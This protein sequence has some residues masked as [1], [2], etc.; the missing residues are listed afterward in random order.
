VHLIWFQKNLIK[1]ITSQFSSLYF[2]N[3]INEFPGR[4]F[5]AEEI[6]PKEIK[7]GEKFNIITK[8]YP[9]KPEEIKK[10]TK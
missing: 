6:N 1:K 8:N 10:N 9:L 2:G 7:K 5:E 4:I 3:L